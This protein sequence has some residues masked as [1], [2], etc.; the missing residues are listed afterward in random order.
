MEEYSGFYTIMAD[1]DPG[2]RMK[3]ITRA[4]DFFIHSYDRVSNL[5][6]GK[7]ANVVTVST[8]ELADHAKTLRDKSRRD[9]DSAPETDRAPNQGKT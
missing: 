6:K 9:R 1:D 5:I 2:E 3:T 7:K 4:V 8:A